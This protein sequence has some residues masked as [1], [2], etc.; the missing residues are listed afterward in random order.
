VKI[1]EGDIVQII[2]ETDHWFPCLIVV[3]EVK[4][5]GVQG[6]VTIPRNGE[7]PNGNAYRRLAFDKVE[8][9]GRANIVVGRHGE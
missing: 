8:R 7:D 2:D 5:W 1:E 9:V 3:S 6:Y 4:T